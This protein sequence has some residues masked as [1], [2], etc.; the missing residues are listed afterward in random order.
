M[1]LVTGASGMVGGHLLWFL[2]QEN[3]QV[4]AIIRSPESLKQIQTIFSFYTAAPT[5]YMSRIVLVKADLL[6]TDS[7]ERALE[8]IETV[9]HCAAVVSTTNQS[10]SIFSTNVVGTQNMVNAAMSAGVKRFCFVSSIAACG[11]GNRVI[12][13]NTPW[14]DTISHSVY[15]LSKYASEQ[16]VMAAIANGLNAVIVNPGVILGVSGSENGSAKIFSQVRKGLPFYT[17]GGTGYVDV[18]DVVKIMIALTH[19]TVHSEKFILSTENCSNREILD[20][21]ADAF[22]KRRPFI[23]LGKNVLKLI[24]ALSEIFGIITGITPIVDRKSAETLCKRE[25]YSSEKIRQ[26]LDYKFIPITES[27]QD[28][29]RFMKAADWEK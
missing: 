5:D 16:E 19:S 3:E 22:G 23:P 28:V 4:K 10:E 27:I 15:A 12:T 25:Y 9:Y 11:N 8:G 26:L 14:N 21:I 18:R 17:N 29:C 20:H 2:L 24:A 1:I 6:N 13:E 7:L